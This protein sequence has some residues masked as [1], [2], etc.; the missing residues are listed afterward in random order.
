MLRASLE[1]SGCPGGGR[2]ERCGL[3][4]GRND[5]W[6]VVRERREVPVSLVSDLAN[7]ILVQCQEVEWK[8][9]YVGLTIHSTPRAGSLAR[10]GTP[11]TKAQRLQLGRGSDVVVFWGMTIG[12]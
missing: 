5:G 8:A 10:S 1:W 2:R 11:A 6:R 3:Y 12:Q 9:V 7:A 4:A